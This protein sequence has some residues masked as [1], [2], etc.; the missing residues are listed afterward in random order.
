MREKDRAEIEQQLIRLYKK[1]YSSK[2]TEE[3]LE[4][5]LTTILSDKI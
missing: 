4:L 5:E 3:E 2:I 1:Y